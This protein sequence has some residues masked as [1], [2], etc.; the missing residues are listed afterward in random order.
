MTHCHH[1]A[2]ASPLTQFPSLLTGFS[3]LLF[4]E[5]LLFLAIRV[6]QISVLRLLLDHH[7]LSRWL[8]ETSPVMSGFPG[9]F[10]TIS[11]SSGPPLGYLLVLLFPL[12]LLVPPSFVPVAI[13]GSSIFLSCY[14]GRNLGLTLHPYPQPGVLPFPAVDIPHPTLPSLSVGIWPSLHW[15]TPSRYA[16]GLH[17]C[18]LEVLVQTSSCDRSLP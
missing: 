3:F 6:S 7:L 9:E 4:L 5:I 8:K 13:N 12:I 18:V 2:Y 14:L 16:C 1:L 15:S 10:W 17:P 11:P